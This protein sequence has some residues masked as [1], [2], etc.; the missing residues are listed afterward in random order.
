MLQVHPL[1]TRSRVL[2]LQLSLQC[3]I[4]RQQLQACRHASTASAPTAKSP[5]RMQPQKPAAPTLPRPTT[6]PVPEVNPLINPFAK[7][8]SNGDHTVRPL[9]RPLGLPTAPLPGKNTGIATRTWRQR[10]DDFVNY[11]KHLEKRRAL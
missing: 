11:D 1:S 2:L 8:P 4:A 6:A 10:R 3:K 7:E 9:S 5:S